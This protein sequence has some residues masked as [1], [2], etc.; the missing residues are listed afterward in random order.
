M[1]RYIPLPVI[2]FLIIA[3]EAEGQAPVHGAGL[4]YQLTLV[5]NPAL[6]GSG[7]DGILRLSYLNHY[8]GNNFDLHSV[9]LSY[10][11]YFPGLH[12]GAG[13][14][15][16]NEYLGGIINDLHGGMAYSYYF[17]AGKDLF[18]SAGL[19]ASFFHRG[20]DFSGALLP[21]QIDPTGGTIN[22]PGELLYDR[23][24][25]IFDLGTGF[26][27]MSGNFFAGLAVNHLTR[28]DL[29]ESEHA[30]SELDRQLLL[31]AAWDLK[32]RKEENIGI[33]PM[34]RIELNKGFF[35]MGAGAVFR[36]N[37]LSIN[38]ILFTDNNK[39][40][41]AQAGFSFS[42]GK[43]TFFYNYYFNIISPENLLPFSLHHHTGVAFSL[44]YVDKR[45][46]IK[47]IKF[48]EL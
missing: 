10:D 27:V 7:G 35:S 9:V 40:I 12:G 31:H 16:H 48:P 30:R 4:N 15:F 42:T 44:N 21:D 19:S 32:L 8:P 26:L 11:G 28:P 43:A 23:G 34:A 6:A 17:R 47:T 20:F 3:I 37:Y 41:D 33:C 1:L 2:I 25:T 24:R 38:T 14:Y 22:P 29:S 39:N 13:V 5:S 18:F 46:T 36:S 45:K